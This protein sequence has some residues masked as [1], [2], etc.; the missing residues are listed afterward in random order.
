MTPQTNPGAA[1]RRR[2]RLGRMLRWMLRRRHVLMPLASFAA[3]CASYLL[4]ERSA[5]MAQGIAVLVLA[6][7][8]W[9]LAEP[10]LAR[11]LQRL[12]RGRVSPRLLPLVTQS[13]HQETLFFA[14]PFVAASTVWS[15]AQPLFLA[16]VATAALVTTLDRVYIDRICVHPGR[17]MLF[18]AFCAFVAALVVVPLALHRDTTSALETAAV[19]MLLGLLPGAV[20]WLRVTPTR[21]WPRGAL[22]VLLLLAAGWGLRTQVPAVGLEAR[23]MRAVSDLESELAPG[24]AVSRIGVQELQQRGLTAFAAIRAPLGLHQALVF[25]WRHDGRLIERIPTEITGGREAGYRTFTRK[26]N[27]PVDPVGRWTISL[28]T[29]AGQLLA[30]TE[31][32]VEA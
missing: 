25:E 27:F 5:A 3:G 31:L 18:Q 28:R 12:S 8:L 9:I 1:W 32:L 22:L 26:H 11:L 15:S 30:R 4:V 13:L 6:G 29:S 19:L 14:L 17:L 23:Q 2:D 20:R 24:P 10:L 21:A 7:W 16:M